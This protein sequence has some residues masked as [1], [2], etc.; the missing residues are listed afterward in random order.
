MG[1]RWEDPPAY[2]PARPK[3]CERCRLRTA[4]VGVGIDPEWLCLECFDLECEHLGAVFAVLEEALE[5]DT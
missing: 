4:C 3:W 1:H 5:G 2:K